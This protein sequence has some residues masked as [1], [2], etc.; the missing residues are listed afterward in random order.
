MKRAERLILVLFLLLIICSCSFHRG[1]DRESL[2][3]SP[4]PSLKGQIDKI[5]IS[6]LHPYT[7]ASIKAVSL[8]TGSTVYE[9]NPRMLMTPASVEKL[10]TAAAALWRL[11]AGHAL[12]T[13]VHMVPSRGEI[14]VKGCGDPLFTVDE[15]ALMAGFIAGDLKPGTRCQIIGD[16]GCFDDNYWG[17]GWAW[18]DDPDNEAVYLSALS[19]NGNLAVLN[20]APGKAPGLPLAVK[21]APETRYLAVENRGITGTPGGSCSVSVARPAGDLRNHIFIGGTPAPGC[22][23]Q[24]KKL[25]VWRPELYFLTLLAEQLGRAGIVTES[26]N[27]GSVSAQAAH[28]VSIRRPVGKIV[29]VMLKKSDNLGGENL[30][31]YMGHQYTGREGSAEDGVLVIMGYLKACGIPSENLRIADGSG[32]SHY[33]LSNAETIVQLLAAVYRDKAIYQEFVNS[34]PVAGRDGTL[35]RRM[36]GT[37]A[38]GKLRAKTGSLKGISTL[39]GYTETADG[40]PLAFAVMIENFTGP[41]QRIRDIQDRIAVLLSTASLKG[42]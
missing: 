1:A 37:P 35:V 32:M 12:E 8:K 25:P 29:N 20:I 2:S 15:I 9:S 21:V 7:S 33:N 14:Y 11:G 41:A 42:R 26:I 31:K 6:E 3:A 40:E 19:V 22:P 38:E 23:P 10:F 13:S 28:L 30:L 36:K 18:E 4:Y 27:L 39:A 16:V 34:L 5:I 17:S 24:E